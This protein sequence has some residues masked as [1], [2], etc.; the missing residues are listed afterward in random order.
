MYLCDREI[1]DILPQL[2]IET[3]DPDHSFSDQ[4]QIQPC[5]IDIRLSD[6]FWVPVSRRTVIDL[7]RSSLLEI[8][9]RRHWKRIV[10]KPHECRTIKP[11]EILLGRTYEKFTIPPDYAGK[12]EGRSSFA[13]MG[14]AIHSTGDFI[15]PGWRGHM[16]LQLINF[17]PHPIK[18][19]P[20]VPICQL[21]LIK[22][23]NRPDRIYGEGSLQS[24]YMDDDGGPSYWWRDKRIKKMQ[25]ALGKFD[26]ATAVQNDI[27][28]T[29]GI[30]EPEILE[31]FE[32]YIDNLPRASL[33]SAD[34]ALSSFA[35]LE[36]RKRT[37][38]KML[39]WSQGV[40]FALLGSLS[41]RLLL[42]PVY[43]WYFYLIWLLT[44]LSAILAARIFTIEESEYLGE[45][46]LRNT[47]KELQEK[48]IKLLE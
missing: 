21:I 5:S 23:S 25:S 15:N 47:S 40:P 19:F 24:K 4:E 9:P 22:L 44:I 48:N 30:Q 35:H 10:L 39:R 27:L 2:S 11:G 14:L 6:V 34:A 17:G 29:I 43:Y 1:R 28:N 37:I 38:D 31:R 46:E 18:L 41:I 12:L 42:E 8:S 16:P 20:F 33:D 32:I 36:D 7:R 45:K 13:R 26:I 3:A